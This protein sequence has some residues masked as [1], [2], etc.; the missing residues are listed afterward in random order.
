MELLNFLNEHK[1]NW[2]NELAAAPYFL[3]ISKDGDYVLFKYNAYA[4][5]MGNEIVQEARGSIFYF[6][7]EKNEWECVCYPF[8]K[9]FNAVEPHAATD[10]IDWQSAHVLQKVDGS[11]IKFWYHKN[12]WYISTNGTIDAAKAE[13]IEGHT[14]LSL[15]NAAI[16]PGYFTDIL[17]PRF[18]YMFELTSPWNKIIIDYHDVPRLWYLGRRNMLTLEEDAIIPHFP[19][20]IKIPKLYQL[21]SLSECLAAAREMDLSEEGYVVVDKNFNR[22]KVKGAAYLAAHKIRPNGAVTVKHIVELW[23]HDAIDDFIAICPE[24]NDFVK[25]IISA[26]HELITIA[27]DTYNNFLP[28]SSDRKTFAYCA[29]ICA[30]TIKTYLFARLDGKCE[31]ALDFYKHMPI[32]SYIMPLLKQRTA[33]V[34]DDI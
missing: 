4:S 29:N 24:Y 30:A 23:Q 31:S 1:E 33:G 28:I 5:D 3:N 12:R 11:L 32:V 25:D 17:D 27:D 15:V 26:I 22:I 18:T 14:Y 19:E 8:K 13:A 20:Y 10:Y 7:I 34:Q 6:N 9:F 16:N 21:S 2:E